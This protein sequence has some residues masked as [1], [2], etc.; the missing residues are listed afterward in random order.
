MNEITPEQ[1]EQFSQPT[2]PKVDAN[3]EATQILAQVEREK[4]DLR[5][6][7]EMAK[8]DLER[9][10]MQL[11]NARKQLELQM[12]EMKIQADAENNAEKTRGD[13]TKIIIEALS[14]F[15]E[16]QKGDMNVG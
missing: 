4:A 11:D 5:S 3:V 16:M 10:Q 2:P 13:Q 1:N 14:K 7:T 12:Q 8:L 9:E 6:K 15:N